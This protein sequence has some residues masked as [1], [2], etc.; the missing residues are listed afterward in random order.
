MLLITTQSEKN[1]CQ[2]INYNFINTIKSKPTFV[3][4]SISDKE[5]KDEKV[6]LKEGHEHNHT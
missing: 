5:E 1:I 2:F 6:I 4:S 3:K